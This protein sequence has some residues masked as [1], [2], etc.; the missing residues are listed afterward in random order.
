VPNSRAEKPKS[1]KNKV[2]SQK[3][4][5]SQWLQKSIMPS[6]K[7]RLRQL[8]K[9]SNSPF[10]GLPLWAD[11]LGIL[12]AI[13]YF[14]P[15]V[16]IDMTG[17]FDPSKKSFF[18]NAVIINN[19]IFPLENVTIGMRCGPFK[20]IPMDKSFEEA[21]TVLG[22]D[23]LDTKPFSQP[24][25]GEKEW[26]TDEL[27]KGQ[28]FTVIL[29]NPIKIKSLLVWPKSKAE[30]EAN[31]GF[32]KLFRIH[33]GVVVDYNL[34]FLPF[35]FEKQQMFRTVVVSKDRLEWLYE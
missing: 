12:V 18:G 32:F 30:V 3:Q 8:K 35:R 31:P 17:T 34:W 11:I 4:K 20:Y 6:V 25:F 10:L 13:L 16:G 19:G 1:D 7:L 5:L 26:K 23:T 14:F 24:G 29:G 15:D 28:K 33:I 2:I 9:I 21:E 22:P 27:V